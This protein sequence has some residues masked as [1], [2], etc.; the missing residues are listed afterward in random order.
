M[1]LAILLAI[2]AA[3]CNAVATICQRLG[4]EQSAH[5]QGSTLGLIRGVFRRPIWF[6]GLL[7]MTLAFGLQALALSVG[8]LSSVQPVMV[9]E[10]VFLVVIIGTWF[11]GQLTWREWL[12]SVGTALALGAFLTLSAPVGGTTQPSAES[13]L[14]LDVASGGAVVVVV[15]ASR[16]GS[17]VWR[18]AAFGVAA[19]ICYA[20]TAACVKSVA[21]EWSSGV[22]QLPRHPGLYGA[23]VAGAIGLVLG[24]RALDSGPVAASQSV[25][26]IV[27]PIVSIVMGTWLFGDHWQ[28]SIPR[29]G[30]AALALALMFVALSVLATSPLITSTGSGEVLSHS[31]PAA[32]GGQ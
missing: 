7:I 30:G 21:D 29:L 9:T 12:G 27:N 25:L 26:L 31:R 32:V 24:Q 18:A 4:V 20:L 8:T 22:A 28:A 3:A 14:L 19:A 17:R 6:L 23:I 13:W 5:E 2:V 1:L 10:I 11:R 16:R 15:F